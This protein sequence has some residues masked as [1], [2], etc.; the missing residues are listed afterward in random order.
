MFIRFNSLRHKTLL[1]LFL[2]FVVGSACHAAERG[3]LFVEETAG[4]RRFGY[5][6]QANLTWK[7]HVDEGTRFR[8]L[9]DGKPIPAQFRKNAA[10]VSLDFDASFLPEEL[11]IYEIEYG[12]DVMPPEE[13]EPGMMIDEHDDHYV[14][15]HTN[16]LS[17]KIRKDLRGFL[18]TVTT[19]ELEF[20]RS[21]S[22]GFFVKLLEGETVSLGGENS[23][24][25][26]TGSRIT[27]QGPFQCELE[28]D[29]AVTHGDASIPSTIHL[30]FPRSKSWVQV[31]WTFDDPDDAIESL[32]IDLNLNIVDQPTLVDFGAGSL[33]YAPLSSGQTAIMNAYRKSGEHRW[34]V[35]RGPADHPEPYMVQSD[36]FSHYA[37]GWAHVMD[38]ER[39][40]AISVAYFGEIADSIQVDA[41]GRTQIER[42]K[43]IRKS[44]T[45]ELDVWYHFVTM[46][47]HVGAATSPQSMMMPLKTVW[48]P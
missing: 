45:K 9:L 1:T 44:K 32:G 34:N 14:I 24:A 21:E 13:P 5:P 33:V 3:E 40:T 2:M 30:S 26:V 7:D 8:L 18:E 4:I 12:D 38:K 42:T 23:P 47:V 19:P 15:K 17:W 11:R 41:D 48:K 35:L 29:V 16:Y 10:G 20:M 27:K 36:I 39:C 25:R 37:E 46:P 31:E 28:F 43:F 22:A 6:V